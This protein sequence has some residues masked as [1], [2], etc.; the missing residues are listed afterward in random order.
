M[1]VNNDDWDLV[2]SFIEYG[3][4]EAGMEHVMDVGYV[5]LPESL[6]E[7]MRARIG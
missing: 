3:F 4:S 1:N 5:A 2:R 7:E 6:L